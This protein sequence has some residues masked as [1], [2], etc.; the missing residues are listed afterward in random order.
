MIPGLTLLDAG[1][2]HYYFTPLRRIHSLTA[3]A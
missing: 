3:I 1:N 2:S